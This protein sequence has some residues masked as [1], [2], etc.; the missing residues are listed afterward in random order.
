MKKNPA[1][2]VVGVDIGGT[3]F[4]VGLVNEH[5]GRVFQISKQKTAGLSLNKFGSFLERIIGQGRGKTKALG[6]AV[7]GFCD[8]NQ[9]RVLTTCGV[10]PFLE[11]C[12]LACALEKRFG[13][14]TR[15]D[16]D[17]RAHAE[18]EFSY[19]G[20][21]KPKS[22]V[23]LTLGTGV[24]LAWRYC[25]RLHPPPNHGAM[26]GHMAISCRSGNPCY[27]GICG[28]LESLASGTAL[29]AAANECLSRFL[30]SS[31]KFPVSSQDVCQA[32][33]NDRLA[34]SCI[35]RAV[36]ALR[37]ALYNLHHFYFPDIVVLGGGLSQG[38]WPY[39]RDVRNWFEKLQRYDGGTNRLVLSRLGDRAGVL[40]AAALAL[41][42]NRSTDGG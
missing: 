31:L 42:Q 37:C 16:N 20:W 29:S 8:A 1:S 9:Q 23:V 10:V 34:Q 27:C 18:G 5:T 38:L 41:E 14:R 28:C 39:L 7:P 22:F 17:A 35:T 24:G 32:G 4:R 21:G 13:V 33:A 6:I 36:E 15:V 19:G 12:D 25:G 11:S 2:W 3:S 26:G 40:G 30:P